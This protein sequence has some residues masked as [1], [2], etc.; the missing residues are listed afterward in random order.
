MSKYG[1]GSSG[2]VHCIRTLPMLALALPPPPPRRR[3]GVVDVADCCNAARHLV[4]Q[5]LV[6]AKRLCIS[7][8]SAGG[9]TTLAC[10]AFRCVPWW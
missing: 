4:K 9:Y 3:W 5:S 2:W 8:G 6:D 1:G 7:G 10:L